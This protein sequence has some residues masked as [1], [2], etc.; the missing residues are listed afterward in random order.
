MPTSNLRYQTIQVQ[1]RPI[2]AGAPS[3]GGLAV[4]A[5]VKL[6]HKASQALNGSAVKSRV[7]SEI[8]KLKPQINTALDR[9]EQQHRQSLKDAGVL[10]VVGIQEWE[11]PDATGAR[12]QMF[13]SI[14]IGGVGTSPA[15]VI[16]AYNNQP[17]LVQGPARGWVRKDD[18]IW[19]S[20][21]R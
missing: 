2:T 17:R 20:R 9:L 1:N 11:R 8:E 7:N 15:D 18:Y 12:A 16:R 13:L 10:L 3:A 21:E 5:G 6:L 4:G 14:H 19:V